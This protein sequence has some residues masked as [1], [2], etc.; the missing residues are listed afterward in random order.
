MQ[1]RLTSCRGRTL[2][3]L[4][5]VAVQSTPLVLLTASP[6]SAC[7]EI[8]VAVPP[9]TDEGPLD[10]VW[11]SVVDA[12]GGRDPVDLVPSREQLPEH[13]VLSPSGDIGTSDCAADPLFMLGGASVRAGSTVFSEAN[14]LQSGSYGIRLAKNGTCS[15]SGTY[16]DFLG[17]TGPAFVAP[18]M[19]P[20]AA[21]AGSDYVACLTLEGAPVAYTQ[22]P[23]E[24]AE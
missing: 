23:M 5:A 24:V 6:A 16:Y 9:V 2:M 3:L 15:A 8:G 22:V 13:R 12:L 1:F 19:V 10:P 11:S 4:V 7:H 18:W 17:G 20:A 14:Y 21:P